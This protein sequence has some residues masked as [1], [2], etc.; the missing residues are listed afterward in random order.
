MSTILATALVLGVINFLFYLLGRRVERRTLGPQPPRCIVTVEM[1]AL[2]TRNPRVS[3]S[4]YS[5][6]PT[7]KT[8]VGVYDFPFVGA[9]SIEMGCHYGRQ[10]AEMIGA[11]YVDTTVKDL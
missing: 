4:L 6:T 11:L 1:S 9:H 8:T 10:L 7:R 5:E 3:I 2:R